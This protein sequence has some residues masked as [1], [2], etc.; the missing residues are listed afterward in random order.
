MYIDFYRL[1]STFFICFRAFFCVLLRNL[2]LVFFLRF[3]VFNG[4]LF[5]HWFFDDQQIT[6]SNSVSVSTHKTTSIIT[7]CSWETTVT[8]AKSDQSILHCLTTDYYGSFFLWLPLSF[9]FQF[10][11]SKNCVIRQTFY[12]ISKYKTINYKQTFSRYDL[13]QLYVENDQ[14]CRQWPRIFWKIALFEE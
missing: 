7:V 8:N 5:V 11:K 4:P 2:V 13:Q 14:C 9:G 1:F 3:G 12:F 10:K 6:G